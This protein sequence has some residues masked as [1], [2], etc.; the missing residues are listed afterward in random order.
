MSPPS[1]KECNRALDTGAAE[2]A[3][4]LAIELLHR[5]KN[6]IDALTVC[7]RAYRL[8]NDAANSARVL[9]VILNID[10]LIDWAAAELGNL[11][12]LSG[13]IDKA[14]AVL[15]K[16]VELHPDNAAANAHLG[17]VFSELNQLSAGEWHFRHALDVGSP[18]C[19]TMTNL[20][21]NLTRQERADEAGELYRQAHELEPANI[22]TIAY[23]AKLHEVRGEID[24]AKALLDK[25][26]AM[27]PGSV[28]L[29]VATLQARAGDNEGALATIDRGR[30]LNGDAL[31]ERGLIKDRIGDFD[32]AWEDFAEAKRS[33]AIEAGG[34]RYDAGAVDKF[35]GELTE[36]FDSKSMRL[37][38]KAAR[39]A[40]TAQPLFIIGAPRSGTTLVERILASHSSVEAGGE[41]PFIQDLRVFSEKLLPETGFPKNIAAAC[42]ADRRHV[43]TLFRDFY[44]AQRDERFEP[45][46]GTEFVTDKMPFNEMYLPLIR[47]AFPE[48]PVVHVSRH[49]LDVAVS[50]FSN[51]LNHGFHCAY[52][53]EDILHHLN[54]VAELHE[55][56]RQQFDTREFVVHYEKLASDP[57]S[58]VRELLDYIGLPFEE[59]C[60][61]FHEERRFVATPS[62][63]QVDSRIS[64]RSV[65]RHRNYQR[66]LAKIL[67][68]D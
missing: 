32:G 28:D 67:P 16:A 25:A 63:R 68:P 33:L 41:L 29:L 59:R 49:R 37:M 12:F 62:Y 64:N 3:L 66:Q 1:I 21:L 57:E 58:T 15:R 5:N 26:M 56:Y 9:E 31:L 11:Y 50:M 30:K 34:L 45:A 52:R 17:T 27:Q 35:F 2:E 54:A 23:W 40:G 20:A 18:D 7:Y 46:S 19:E 48:C 61:R 8:K 44:L 53:I 65:G 13:H 36:A 51:K 47:L 22:R 55:Q 14:E 43:I 42:I 39:R 38:P 60:L 4:R 6:D 24:E 10:P